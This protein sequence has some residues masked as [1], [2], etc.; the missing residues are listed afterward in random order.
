[1]KGFYSCGGQCDGAGEKVVSVNFALVS[2]VRLL[3][4]YYFEDPFNT[5]FIYF[6]FIKSVAVNKDLSQPLS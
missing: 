3:F 6:I 2:S 4:L 5:Y 1:M